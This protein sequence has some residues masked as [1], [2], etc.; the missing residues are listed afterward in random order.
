MATGPLQLIFIVAFL[1]IYG[2]VTFRLAGPQPDCLSVRDFAEQLR[3]YQL[4]LDAAGLLHRLA[5]HPSEVSMPPVADRRPTGDVDRQQEPIAVADSAR[6]SADT[7]TRPPSYF[8]YDDLPQQHLLNSSFAPNVIYYVWCGR[9][10]FEFQHYLSVMSVIR[11]LRPDNIVFCYDNEPIVD[12]WTYNTWYSEIADS[13]PFFRQHRLLPEEP[14]CAGHAIPNMTFVRTYLL[15]ATGGIYMNENTILSRYSLDLRLKQMVVGYGPKFDDDKAPALLATKPGLPGHRT[16]RHV[17][18]DSS[19]STEQLTCY[20][21]AEFVRSNRKSPC[22]VIDPSSSLFPK[23]IWDLDDSFGRL[24][25]TVFYGTPAIRRPQARYD[26]QLIPNIAHIV[27]LG[28]GQMDFL[29]Y[30][31]VASLIYVAQVDAVYIHGD[32]PPTGTYWPLIKDHPKLHL[33]YRQ[34]PGYVRIIH[35]GIGLISNAILLS[36]F[37]AY[38]I[39]I[40]TY[41]WNNIYYYVIRLQ[42]ALTKADN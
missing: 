2:M 20:T 22:V 39:N 37:I 18:T 28:G 12:S 11:L 6:A 42:A 5:D 34:H 24:A 23:D 14:G 7:T 30:L 41:P 19:L 16:I 38:Q 32:G 4:H 33:I 8:V 9:R 40:R 31:C 10:W 13:Y 17:L 26:D 36:P 3:R 15:T 29:F 1:V 27:W 21:I 35:C 25:R